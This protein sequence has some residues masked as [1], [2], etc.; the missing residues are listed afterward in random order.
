MN[1]DILL[2][3]LFEGVIEDLDFEINEDN[4]ILS[5][6]IEFL[7]ERVIYNFNLSL[8]FVSYFHNNSYDDEVIKSEFEKLHDFLTDSHDILKNEF[9][10]YFFKE[11]QRFSIIATYLLSEIDETISIIDSWNKIEELKERKDVK[12]YKE[13]LVKHFKFIIRDY[14][15]F[16]PNTI[17]KNKFDFT[18]ISSNYF[19]ENK[20]IS[21]P[22]SKHLWS[23]ELRYK[24]IS[25]G[26]LLKN[27]ILSDISE[28]EKEECISQIL[29]I[30]IDTA[31]KIKSNTYGKGRFSDKEEE[32]KNYFVDKLK[33]S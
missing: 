20:N 18:D 21:K 2:S 7:C 6:D 16:A 4:E 24:L 19:I 9:K 32:R 26:G 8:N 14:K 33:S 13:S 1:K 12:D 11:P 23:A 25:E 30:N 27:L 28:R 17:I 3:E 31:R 15:S 5:H 29:G 10:T 22:K